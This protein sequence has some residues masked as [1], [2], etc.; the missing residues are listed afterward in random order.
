VEERGMAHEHPEGEQPTPEEEVE[1]ARDALA[2]GDAAHAAHHIGGALG[3]RPNDPEVLALIDE[4][5]NSV[6]GDP[7]QVV[8]LHENMYFGVV[9]VRAYLLARAGRYDEAIA[10]VCQVQAVV[11]DRPF[12]DWVEWWLDM[13]GVVDAIDAHELAHGFERCLN[14]LI[15]SEEGLPYHDPLQERML[16]VVRRV[17]SER[18]QGGYLGYFHAVR[19]RRAGHRDEAEQVARDLHTSEP[20]YLTAV[21]LGG[22]LREQGK[23][24]D[25]IEAFRAA[26]AHEPDDVAVLLD[27]GDLL[28]EDGQLQRA[29]EHYEEV[30]TKDPQQPWALATIAYLQYLISGEG[31]WI[32]RL[33]A[34]G[35]QEPTNQRALELLDAAR[36]Y[37]L[38]LDPP[39]SSIVNGAANALQR[40]DALTRMWVSGLEPPSARLAVDWVNALLAPEAG[41]LEVEVGEVPKA[42]PRLP[43]RH[44]AHTLWRY[45]GTDP[46]P[47]L[48]APGS[49]T[50]ELIDRLAA[51]P[52]ELPAWSRRAAEAAQ[53]LQPEALIELLGA[54]VHRPPALPEGMPPWVWLFR[55]QLT[56]AL[57]IAHLDGD[58]E[59]SRRREGLESLLFGP[60]DWTTTAAI[61][62]TTA[63]LNEEP[64][65]VEQVVP[66]LLTLLEIPGSPI[67]HQCVEAPLL[68]CLPRLDGLDDASRALLETQRLELLRELT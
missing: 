18:P 12:L 49:E 1:L 20:S 24:E 4:L 66:D 29:L 55:R 33:T 62:A 64:Q 2:D 54:M 7:L 3:D 30:L 6:E 43:A 38:R 65:L 51:N 15:R 13:P 46:T 22:A 67:W 47:N 61:L 58:W 60:L 26:L 56:A 45:D 25:A 59:G 16:G 10:L 21:A 32:E 11:P 14:T 37:V 39:G 23:L 17:R 31:T 8:P 36:P 63:L 68:H 41:P 34:L 19:A 9:A 57:L 28:L 44:V 5:A 42:D 35:E 53:R 48:P 27:V 40:G 52:Y 50:H